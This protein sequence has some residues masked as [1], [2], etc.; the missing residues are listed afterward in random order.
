MSYDPS[1]SSQNQYSTPNNQSSFR[2]Q[3]QYGNAPPYQTGNF[4]PRGPQ[5]NSQPYNPQQ[6]QQ[7]G[8][9]Q[10]PVLRRTDSRSYIP[11]QQPANLLPPNPAGQ[12]RLPLNFQPQNWN[13]PFR[14]PIRPE[15]VFRPQGQN[16]DQ[17]RPQQIN[18]NGDQYR[19][20]ENNSYRPID[21]KRNNSNDQ[22]RPVIEQSRSQEDYSTNE[23]GAKDGY[24]PSQ[25]GQYYQL[26]QQRQQTPGQQQ[27][28]VQQYPLAQRPPVF[29]KPSPW[30]LLKEKLPPHIQ[31]NRFPF[32]LRN[33][34]P[35]DSMNTNRSPSA[36]QRPLS[37][38]QIP[39][40]LNGQP[41]ATPQT[42][43]S[44]ME[45]TT[46]NFSMADMPPRQIPPNVRPIR[47][48]MR[49]DSRMMS[50]ND[51]NFRMPMRPGMIPSGRDSPLV[52]SP[53]MRMPNYPENPNY[54][55]PPGMNS[56]QPSSTTSS[57]PKSH[58]SSIDE[59]EEKRDLPSRP[60]S[61]GG[62]VDPRVLQEKRPLNQKAF[63]T[64]FKSED[65]THQNGRNL[66][67][68]EMVRMNTPPISELQQRDQS[69][70]A[71]GDAAT[72]SRP[73]RPTDLKI[74]DGAS[75]NLE[76]TPTTPM[77]PISGDLK[78]TS[79]LR[80]SNRFFNKGSEILVFLPL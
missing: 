44:Q 5:I 53:G 34:T 43:N 14:P 66:L 77:T 58:R 46:L 40:Q 42:P 60:P 69:S 49:I 39:S 12:Q 17:Y 52:Q 68:P 72:L 3:S 47:P 16:S 74:L 51:P 62:N 48:L 31:G 76:R 37:G 56:S 10:G 63:D 9:Q 79:S 29:R 70:R 30:S 45:R 55:R 2:P 57:T 18:Q 71:L 28:P 33:A 80:Q 41:P 32:P 15:Q 13:R 73:N 24:N 65:F 20:V 11:P 75:N 6:F 50:P 67:R 23:R 59:D 21:V 54:Q 25:S 19:P 1:Q 78:R 8:P 26:N 38:N 27:P 4:V 36:E 7:R 61:A 35:P 64:N 22:L